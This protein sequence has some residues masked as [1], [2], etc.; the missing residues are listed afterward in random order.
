MASLPPACGLVRRHRGAGF[1]QPAYFRG[2]GRT[3]RLWRLRDI[4]GDIIV[5][6]TT[7]RDYPKDLADFVANEGAEHELL[8]SWLVQEV[9]KGEKLPGSIRQ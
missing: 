9:E 4:S 8:E 6:T 2:L 7:A 1:R 3:D 5:A